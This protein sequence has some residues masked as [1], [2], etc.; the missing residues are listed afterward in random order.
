MGGTAVSIG[1][2]TYRS[3]YPRGSYR[4]NLNFGFYDGGGMY[5]IIVR[6][7]VVLPPWA[8]FRQTA[9]VHTTSY[10]EESH[11]LSANSPK[12]TLTLHSSSISSDTTARDHL[13]LS[14]C[15]SFLFDKNNWDAGGMIYNVICSTL[16]M[17]QPPTTCLLKR[18][19]SR[20]PKDRTMWHKT[21]FSC[22][23]RCG[24]CLARCIR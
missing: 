2:D 1:Y 6:S 16:L 3:S 20:T 7:V 14:V 5:D 13:F 22:L 21:G 11:Q 15:T 10:Q 12:A 4:R 18:D 23:T 19:R 17:K 9:V 8:S 24:G